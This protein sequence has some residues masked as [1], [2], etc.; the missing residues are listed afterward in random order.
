MLTRGEGLTLILLYGLA[1]TVVVFLTRGKERSVDDF[2]LVKRQLGV[3]RGAFSIAAAWIWA[4][5]VFICSLKA[6][7]QGLPGIFWFT[8]PNILCFFTFTP[9]ALRLRRVFPDGYTWPDFIHYRFNGNKPAEITSL[10]VYFGYQLGA[11]IINCVAGGTLLHILTGVDI[12]VTIILMSLTALAYSLI[13][14]LRA[15]RHD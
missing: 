3:F 11:I 5:A 9:L 2:L 6:F 4:P 14:G 15:Q 13:S 1:L 7:T 12:R 10:L 8:A